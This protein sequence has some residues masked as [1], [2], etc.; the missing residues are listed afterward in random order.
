LWTVPHFQQ[1]DQFLTASVGAEPGEAV[2]VNLVSFNVRVEYRIA[3]LRQFAYGH[4]AP[5]QVLE[6]AAYRVLTQTAAARGLLD[7]MGEGRGALA[8]LVQE[9]L[10]A[11]AERLG[12]GVRVM[13]VGVEGVHP[14]T[15]IAD[16]FQ[17]VIGSVEEKEATILAARAEANRILPQA[18]A[19]AEQVRATAAAYAVQRTEIAAA[20]TD[21]FLKRLESYRLAPSVFRTRHYLATF[22]DAIQHARK[23]VVAAAPGSEV[24]QINLEEKLSPDLLDLGPTEKR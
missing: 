2:P 17:S 22:R 13:F 19:E 9:R 6:Q 23:Y 21:R 15:Q 16:A 24:I 14:P 11:E 18:A 1:E 8:G 7:V 10:Q 20:D 12:L 5:G 3:D 4:A